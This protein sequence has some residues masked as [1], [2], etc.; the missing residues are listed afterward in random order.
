MREFQMRI[1]LPT[2]VAAIHLAA[3]GVAGPFDGIYRPDQPWAENW[4]CASVGLDGGALA[5][6]GDT[7]KGVENQCKLT[8]PMPV[9]GMDAILYDAEC[10]GEGETVSYRMMVMRLPEGVAII[11]D[12]FINP[13][14]LCPKP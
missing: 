3:P 7:F 1:L 5:I 6:E 4:D 8:N 14:K 10:S 9:T 2:I 12:G 11:E 13:L